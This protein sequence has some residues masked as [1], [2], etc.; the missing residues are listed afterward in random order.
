[1]DIRQ[2]LYWRNL[3]HEGTFMMYQDSFH[4]QHHKYGFTLP[5]DS[6]KAKTKHLLT[7]PGEFVH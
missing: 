2:A 7:K 3:V 4:F 5:K 1:M 6:K